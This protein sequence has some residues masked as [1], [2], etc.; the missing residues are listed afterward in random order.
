MDGQLRQHLAINIH[1]SLLESVHKTAV[2]DAALLACRVNADDP[3]PL[4]FALSNLSV[5]KRIGHSFD[6]GLFRLAIPFAAV[7]ELPLS[8]F[9]NTFFSFMCRLGISHS[10]HKATASLSSLHRR[11][12][13]FAFLV[14]FPN[15][16]QRLA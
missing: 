11:S 2:R 6:D 9:Q 13:R 15:M 14:I 5:P 3:K 4:K 10:N 16:C 8:F 12:F 7:P 1:I